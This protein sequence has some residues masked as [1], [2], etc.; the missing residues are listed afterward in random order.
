MFHTIKYT[1]RRILPH[2][3]WLGG[4]RIYSL[5][6]FIIGRPQ[7]SSETSKARERRLREGFFDN[8]CGGR[9]LDIGYGGDPVVADC[10]GWDIEHGDAQLLIGAEDEAYD[11]VYSSHTLEHMV[12]LDVALTNWWRVVRPGGH[13]ILYIPHRDLYEKK[14]ALPS[15]WNADHKHFFLLDRD[16]PP[17]TIGIV[18]LLQRVLPEASIV[19]A[20]E[21]SDG[22]TIRTPHIHSDGE[23]SIEVVA[24]KPPIS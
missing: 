16:D 15:N 22:H 11:F 19:Y 17:S 8:F 7:R 3:L 6:Y 20:R 9:G 21:C 1:L 5:L 12:D 18:P 2:P 4:K 23:Y 24:R 13:L 14:Q 10:Q